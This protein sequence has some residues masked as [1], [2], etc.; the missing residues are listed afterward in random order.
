[1]K[2]L[3]TGADGYI[4][5]LAAH[6]LERRGHEVVGLDTGYYRDGWLYSSGKQNT[7]SPRMLATDLRNVDA[8]T[9]EGLDAVV[10]LAELSNDPLGQNNPENT[11]AI[12]H[13][14]SV[15]LARACKTAGVPRFVYTSSCSVYGILSGLY[16]RSQS[17]QAR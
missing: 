12:N 14:G 15:L 17:P 11:F 7:V 13:G 10:H 16:G 3:L 1:M 8:S 5:C 4:G 6:A 9:V 2:I